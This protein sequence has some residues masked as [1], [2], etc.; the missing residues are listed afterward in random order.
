MRTTTRRDFLGTAMAAGTVAVSR[1]VYGSAS[2]S[3]LKVGL[4]GCGG[5]GNVDLNNAFEAGGV[6][7][8]ALCDVDTEHLKNTAD[9]TE[10]KQGSRPKTYKDYRVMLDHLGL[11]VVIIATPPHWHALPF[12]AACGK[13]LHIY[14]EKPL[15]Y[16]I[17][18]GRAMVD[19]HQ[20][21]GNIV[22]I[23]FQR[24][25]TPSLHEVKRFIEQGHAGRIIQV[26]AQI[27]YAIGKRDATPQDPPASL[28]WD[29]WCGPAP[30]LPYSPSVGHIN[31]RLEKTTGHGHLV[32]WGIHKIDQVRVALGE[33]MPTWITAAGGQYA[34]VK[35]ITT[36]D[37][38]TVHFE[39]EHCPVVWRHRIW[40]AAEW[41][42]KTNNG[43]FFYGDKA[44]IFLTNNDWTVIPRGK[45]AE[46]HVHTPDKLNPG[47]AH[48]AEFLE[49]IRGRKPSPCLPLDAFY[50]TATVQLGMIAYECGGP[51]AWD[52]TNERIT[53]SEKAHAMLKRD[54]RAPWKHP[55]PG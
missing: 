9:E 43:I 30:P 7:C 13:G 16:D 22:Q 19:A 8:V 49:S 2:N 35:E 53:N 50:S 31:W 45:S 1:R 41:D 47:V 39:F 17:R 32:D 33:S 23:G 54:Y 14:C 44:T 42:P 28:D 25:Q 24:R 27:H 5:Y 48:M 37:I 52:I 6:E 55:Y 34:C 21:T 3:R 10:K 26:D 29:M 20:K 4:I 51:V 46:R 12:I 38:L 40:G 11:E 36:P 15:A 18:E